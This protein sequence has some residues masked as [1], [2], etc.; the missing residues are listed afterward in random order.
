[1]TG[2]HWNPHSPEFTSWRRGKGQFDRK[3]PKKGITFSEW[4]K[5]SEEERKANREIRLSLKERKKRKMTNKLNRK[6]YW[7]KLEKKLKG[8]KRA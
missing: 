6:S 2:R 7:K 8:K 5:M 4:A 1:M 3:V